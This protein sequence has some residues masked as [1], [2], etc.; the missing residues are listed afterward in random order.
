MGNTRNNSNNSKEVLQKQ[1]I[2]SVKA[3]IMEM[4]VS[5][6]DTGYVWTNSMRSAFNKAVKRLDSKDVLLTS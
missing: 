4:G 1:K 3:L 2:G 6:S 5:L